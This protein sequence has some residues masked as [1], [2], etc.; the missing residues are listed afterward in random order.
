MAS[1]VP[2]KVLLIPSPSRGPPG[3][4]R[5]PVRN[6]VVRQRCPCCHGRHPGSAPH[7]V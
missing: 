1:Q 7:L 4:A 2:V 3:Q 5:E 6:L